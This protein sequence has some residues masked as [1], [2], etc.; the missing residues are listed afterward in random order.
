MFDKKL[1]TQTILDSLLICLLSLTYA[2]ISSGVFYGIRVVD[3]LI[4]LGLIYKSKTKI[5]AYLWIL[6]GLW[7]VSVVLSTLVGLIDKTPYLASDL[8]FFII[9][10]L[11]TLLAFTLAKNTRVKVEYIYYT[12]IIGTLLI[13]LI[14]P[15]APFIKFFY[16]PE[17]FQKEEHLNTIFGPS[18]ILISFLFIYLVF[19]DR[20]RKLLF[21]LSYLVTA[22]AVFN[23]RISRQDLV[24]MLLLLS[25]SLIYRLIYRVKITYLMIVGG[26]MLVGLWFIVNTKDDRVL[27]IIN[28]TEDT[29]FNYRV[30][31]NTDFMIMFNE[32][33]LI[34]KTFGLG[35]G[36]TFI[37]HHNEYLGK[38]ELNILDNTPLTIMMK[39]GYIGLLFYLLILLYPMI[40][41]NWHQ[42][43]VLL[44]PIV[45]SMF[46]FNHAMYNVLYIFGL[47]YVAFRLKEESEQP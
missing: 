39:S 44:F 19:K 29:S 47:Y 25:W 42:R 9:F 1:S 45:L 8:R 14:I 41:V 33:P 4:V 38:R 10:G 23:L 6:T 26:L 37:F 31:S 24:I 43:I 27:G 36:S 32:K 30:I 5:S 3:I 34:N 20:N 28:P 21:Y 16:I 22:L 7:F 40:Y 35:M 2:G 12:L 46:L 13:Y 17:S 11:G 15:T 18:T